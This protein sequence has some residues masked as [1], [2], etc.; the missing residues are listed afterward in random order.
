MGC[1]F[2]IWKLNHMTFLIAFPSLQ[3]FSLLFFL[4]GTTTLLQFRIKIHIFL[5]FGIMKSR[6]Y[7][8]LVKHSNLELDQSSI[9]GCVV[10]GN[11]FPCINELNRC[12]ALAGCA[13]GTICAAPR[14]V[15]K[16]NI[17]PYSVNQPPTYTQNNL[18]FLELQKSK[19]K[20]FFW[21]CSTNTCPLWYQA[22]YGAVI[23]K[24]KSWASSRT[25]VLE[26]NNGTTESWSPLQLKCKQ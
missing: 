2:V 15:A 26:P 4:F 23:W 21:R 22:P 19:D 24:R 9:A 3:I 25:R 17:P 6:N 8:A 7:E 12:R 1:K 10:F 11:L 20:K 13:K 5:P 16:V 14:T 18:R